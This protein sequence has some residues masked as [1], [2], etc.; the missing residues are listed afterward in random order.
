MQRIHPDKKADVMAERLQP[1]PRN[2]V[3]ISPEELFGGRK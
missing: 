1:L 2:K 3:Q